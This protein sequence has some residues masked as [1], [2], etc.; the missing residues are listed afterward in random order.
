M[1]AFPKLVADELDKLGLAVLEVKA[2]G[3]KL[4]ALQAD[5]ND[6]SLSNVDVVI[7]LSQGAT[8]MAAVVSRA[9]HA[10]EVA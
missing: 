7:I 2:V 8:T 3:E 5:A 10:V 6:P 4:V 1:A 9:S